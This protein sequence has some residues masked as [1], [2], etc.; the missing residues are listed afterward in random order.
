MLTEDEAMLTETLQYLGHSTVRE[1]V[2]EALREYVGDGE[3]ADAL[4]LDTFTRETAAKVWDE[5]YQQGR[6]DQADH[7]MYHQ[8]HTANPYRE[9]DSK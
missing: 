2:E 9:G 4:V 1:V 8:T 6:S 3:C 7:S 5:G